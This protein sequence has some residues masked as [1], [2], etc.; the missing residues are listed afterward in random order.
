MIYMGTIIPIWLSYFS[1]WLL[2]HQPDGLFFG[3]LYMFIPNEYRPKRSRISRESMGFLLPEI[4]PG[5]IRPNY[6]GE[7][8]IC[9]NLPRLVGKKNNF[10]W[11]HRHSS[12]FSHVRLSR[13]SEVVEFPLH[14]SPFDNSKGLY[15]FWMVRSTHVISTIFPSCVRFKQKKVI[16]T[17]FPYFHTCVWFILW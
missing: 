14:P 3:G 6:S 16:S 12:S 7:R 2:H 1:R 13:W 11:N 9:F 17:I 5:L 10:V 8:E 4:I 15:H